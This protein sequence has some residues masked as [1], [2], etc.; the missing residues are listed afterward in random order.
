MGV[1]GGNMACGS[2][3]GGVQKVSRLLVVMMGMGVRS[4]L[5]MYA[6]SVNPCLCHRIWVRKLG[7]YVQYES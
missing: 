2:R 6:C 4:Y 1:G 3:G 7:S 5:S